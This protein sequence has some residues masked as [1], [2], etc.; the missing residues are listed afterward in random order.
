MREEPNYIR[1]IPEFAPNKFEMTDSALIHI[2][3][4]RSALNIY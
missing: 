1:Q 4:A 3:M 2:E